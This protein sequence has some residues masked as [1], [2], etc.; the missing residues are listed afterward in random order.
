MGDEKR[1]TS[2]KLRVVTEIDP[3]LVRRLD[4]Y[5]FDHRLASRTAA[6]LFLLKLA[7]EVEGAP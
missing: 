7:L 5:R 1:L 2:E 3:D 6:I 4:E